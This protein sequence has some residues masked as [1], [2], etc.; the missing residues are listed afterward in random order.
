ML[1]ENL[2]ADVGASPR[3]LSEASFGSMEVTLA[4]ETVWERSVVLGGGLCCWQD[5][6]SPFDALGNVLNFNQK[7]IYYTC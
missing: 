7:H 5:I 1:I 6:G 2:T 3:K 4:A